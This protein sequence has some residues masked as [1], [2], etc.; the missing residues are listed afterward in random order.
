[1][2]WEADGKDGFASCLLGWS[3]SCPPAC[4]GVGFEATGPTHIIIIIIII[5]IRI[6]II[7]SSVIILTIVICTTIIISSFVISIDNSITFKRAA[8]R[9][10]CHKHLGRLTAA[11]AP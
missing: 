4:L 8:A 7:S 9:C 5:S 2:R 10:Q 1:M 11:S 6:V 3:D